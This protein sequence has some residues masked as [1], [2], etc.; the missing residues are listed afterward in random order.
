MTSLVF[1]FVLMSSNTTAVRSGRSASG[2]GLCQWVT[3]T[4]TASTWAGGAHI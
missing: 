4:E 1:I 3:S 2:K